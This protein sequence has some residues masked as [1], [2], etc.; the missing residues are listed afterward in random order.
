VAALNALLFG[1]SRAFHRLNNA[2]VVLLPKKPRAATPTDYRP[3]TMIHNFRKL[4]SKLLAMRLA[5]RLKE[6]ISPNQ[7]ASVRGRTIHDN[8]KFVQRAAVY[9]RKK[10]ISKTLLKLD[11]SKA[12][13]TVA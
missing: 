12:F 3:I 2:Y 8:F 7:N 9:L 4:A 5:P 1:D 10:K 11:I 13:D 6:L